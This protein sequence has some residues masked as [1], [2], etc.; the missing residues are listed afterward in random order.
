MVKRTYD[1]QEGIGKLVILQLAQAIG[2]RDAFYWFT[3]RDYREYDKS[4]F[5]GSP[6][7]PPP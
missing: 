7:V 6:L 2:N 3:A 4:M 1:V 5:F